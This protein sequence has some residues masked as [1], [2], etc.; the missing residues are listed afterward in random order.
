MVPRFPSVINLRGFF[1]SGFARYSRKCFL[2][3][4]LCGIVRGPFKFRVFVITSPM[5]PPAGSIP[6]C[7][8]IVTGGRV[9]V[10]VVLF[11]F[12]QVEGKY[13]MT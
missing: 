3:T 9:S 2:P 11:G 7:G 1:V 4:Y 8:A 12:D 5:V 10:T 6:C 13:G